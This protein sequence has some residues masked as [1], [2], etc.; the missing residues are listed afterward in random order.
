MRKSIKLAICIFTV[1]IFLFPVNSNP[2]QLDD[3]PPKIF[4]V[5]ISPDHIFKGFTA[6][7]SATV[8][9]NVAVASVK[10]IITYP[11]GYTENAT[12]KNF[13]GKYY[14]ERYYFKS[15]LHE[16]YIWAID[17]NGNQNTSQI[18]TFYV[19]EPYSPPPEIGEATIEYKSKGIL[20]YTGEATIDL[21][22]KQINV[23]ADHNYGKAFFDVGLGWGV[24]IPGSCRHIRRSKFTMVLR[25]DSPNGTA[26]GSAEYTYDDIRGNEYGG[27]VVDNAFIPMTEDK[28]DYETRYVYAEVKAEPYIVLDL[29]FVNI[30]F[31]WGNS[32]SDSCIIPVNITHYYPP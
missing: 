3:E 25:R 17:T 18:T 7:I 11:D 20:P 14:Y 28:V 4:D 2:I 22:C 5:Q 30:V 21:N 10:V 23:T 8:A 12:M 24:N 31:P 9:D 6:N 19:Q 13:G 32:A 27:F 16:F 15:G 26:I 29:P 1:S